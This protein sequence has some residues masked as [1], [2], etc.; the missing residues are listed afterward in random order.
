M[1]DHIPTDPD[2]SA[3]SGYVEFEFKINE[4]GVV[5]YVKKI[6]GANLTPTVDNF[7]KKNYCHLPL[8][9]STAPNPIVGHQEL[10]GLML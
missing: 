4:Y 3:E 7:Y 1:F 5:V 10:L 9:L 8:N 6:G 2:V